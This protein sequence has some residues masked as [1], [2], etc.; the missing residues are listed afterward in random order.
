LSGQ[1]R[2]RSAHCPDENGY[3]T[4]QRLLRRP[5]RRP[6]T[7][8]RH[9][10]EGDGRVC[11]EAANVQVARGEIEGWVDQRLLTV[12]T[13]FRDLWD[14]SLTCPASDTS[15]TCPT[16]PRAAAKSSKSLNFTHLDSR[17][18]LI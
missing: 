12:R 10:R 14:T 2:L 3:E 9:R 18:L 8:R 15:E 13:G 1:P 17:S 16:N 11:Q 4:R 6:G 7:G 5:P